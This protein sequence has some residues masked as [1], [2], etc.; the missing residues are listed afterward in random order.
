[1]LASPN[2]ATCSRYAG[3]VPYLFVGALVNA[4]ATALAVSKVLEKNEAQNVTVI[5]CGERWKTP[6][7]DGALRF[8]VEDYL[9]AGAI[10]S[11]LQCEKSLEARVCEGAFLH[12]QNKFERVIWSAKVVEIFGRWGL[13]EMC[14][15]RHN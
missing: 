12:V 1:M 15:M 11:Y 3:Q 5:A 2:G 4:Q 9:G 14:N 7:E 8:A 13:M 10:L 6:L